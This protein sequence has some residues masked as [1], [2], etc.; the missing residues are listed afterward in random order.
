MTSWKLPR[1]V[2]QADGKQHVSSKVRRGLRP[3]PK[4]RSSPQRTSPRPDK[5][6]MCRNKLIVDGSSSRC[7][8]ARADNETIALNSINGTLLRYPIC[9]E[10][11]RERQREKSQREGRTREL[12]ERRRMCN[13]YISAIAAT[14]T[15][16]DTTPPPAHYLQGIDL[17][18]SY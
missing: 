5:H 10:G 14:T 2:V 16:I 4:N 9:R 8:Q 6:A 18:T 3:P 7:S 13:I 15:G 17:H 12:G 1:V 11:T